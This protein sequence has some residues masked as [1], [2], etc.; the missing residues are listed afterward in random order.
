MAIEQLKGKPWFVG[1]GVG[2]AIA[3]VLFGLAWW[4]LLSPM[5][6]QIAGQEQ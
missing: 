3:A 4:R 1:A 2:L 5:K 6:G